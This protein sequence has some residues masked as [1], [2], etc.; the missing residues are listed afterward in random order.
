MTWINVASVLKRLQIY[1]NFQ[2]VNEIC[3]L[4]VGDFL[5]PEKNMRLTRLRNSKTAT[6]FMACWMGFDSRDVL[7]VRP[8]SFP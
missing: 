7:E 1:S 5:D 2:G 3:P 4:K 6:E 8:G